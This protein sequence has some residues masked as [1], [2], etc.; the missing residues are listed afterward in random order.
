MP[1]L[2]EPTLRGLINADLNPR[3]ADAN[4]CDSISVGLGFTAVPALSVAAL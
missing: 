4:T 1:S 3:A 2:T